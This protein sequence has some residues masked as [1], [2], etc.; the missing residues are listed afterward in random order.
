MSSANVETIMKKTTT[1]FTSTFV[2]ISGFP[3]DIGSYTCSPVVELNDKSWNIRLYP[4]GFDENSRGY[5]SCF[6]ELVAGHSRASFKI[7]VINQRGWKNHEYLSD[8]VK[9]FSDRDTSFW[10]EPKFV[11]KIDLKNF[12]NGICVNDK[13]IIKVELVIYGDIEHSLKSSS[14]QSIMSSP[15]KK[16]RSLT[17]ELSSTLNDESTSDVTIIAMTNDFSDE[18]ANTATREERIPAH[19]FMLCLRSEVFK[20]MLFNNTMSESLS[21]EIRIPDFDASTIRELLHFI[22][23]DS[24][25]SPRALETLA[26]PL[27]AAACKYQI[28]GLESVCELHLISTIN[29]TNAASVLALSDLYEASHLKSKCLQFI[30]M[31]AKNVVQTEG[32]FEKLGFSLC[33][34]MIKAMVGAEPL[35]PISERKE[36]SA[37]EGERETPLMIIV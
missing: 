21:S 27:L 24:F 2:G 8:G 36:K 3:S 7:S 15:G 16:I 11:S 4:G 22:Y 33:Q 12:S 25:S 19:K 10:G 9:A 35:P 5:I 20:A 32:F 1:S 18:A 31:N 14:S 26:E 23:T 29:V 17:E 34:E 30:A 28:A 6:V 37:P 13:L